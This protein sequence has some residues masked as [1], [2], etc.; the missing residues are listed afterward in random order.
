MTLSKTL[1][2]LIAAFTVATPIALAESPYKSFGTPTVAIGASG[3]ALVRGAIV[4][5]VS[6]TTIVARTS[7]SGAELDWTLRTDSNTD[8]LAKNGNDEELSDIAVGDLISFSGDL[9][10]NL[11]VDVDTVREWPASDDSVNEN[12]DKDA[13]DHERGPWRPFL[14]FWERISLNF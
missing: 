5:S 6:D 8:F 2:V 12:N 13:K 4:R 14:K 1:L 11:V 7:W 10:G 9:D 3:T